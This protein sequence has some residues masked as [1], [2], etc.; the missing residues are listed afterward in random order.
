M[1]HL[2]KLE[3]KHFTLINKY[4][5]SINF[6]VTKRLHLL[7][8]KNSKEELFNNSDSILCYIKY[9]LIAF[10]FLRTGRLLSFSFPKIS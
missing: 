1:S 5:I 8:P 10:V 6:F 2:K 7:S 9:Y 4:E 3:N